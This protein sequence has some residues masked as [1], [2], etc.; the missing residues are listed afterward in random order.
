MLAVLV[1]THFV[2]A[3]QQGRICLFVE[4]VEGDGTSAAR[5]REAGAVVIGSGVSAGNAPCVL[6]QIAMLEA[7]QVRHI[8]V[9]GSK[10]FGYNNNAVML[11]PDHRVEPSAWAVAAAQLLLVL[12]PIGV[13]L[14]TAEFV[15][16]TG[17]L[18]WLQRAVI[19]LATAQLVAPFLP[20][21]WRPYLGR[22]FDWFCKT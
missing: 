6:E 18:Q 12:W 20:P 13:Y 16:S 9:L 15:T 4:F 7:L 3:R 19:G 21:A 22:C 14:A 1:E 8:V 2:L 17:H 10:Q 5:M 11:L